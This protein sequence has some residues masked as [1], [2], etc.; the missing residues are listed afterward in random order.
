M[1]GNKMATWS[2]SEWAQTG[3]G[4]LESNIMVLLEDGEA[5]RSGCPSTCAEMNPGPCQ[6]A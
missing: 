2:E 6:H 3:F 1:E 4:Y 5:R